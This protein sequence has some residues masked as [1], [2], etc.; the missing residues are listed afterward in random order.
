MSTWYWKRVDCSKTIH[1]GHRAEEAHPRAHSRRVRDGEV[2]RYCSSIPAFFT[3]RAYFAFSSGKNFAAYSGVLTLMVL[4]CFA[5]ASF[6]SGMAKAATM[7][8]LMRLTSAGAILA[9]PMVA[10]HP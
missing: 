6:T 7:A 8:S 5:I 2:G 10:N 3:S 1:L 9:G 4:P